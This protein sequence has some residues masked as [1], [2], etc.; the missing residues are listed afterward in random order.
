MLSTPKFVW[1]SENRLHDFPVCFSWYDL[2][3]DN[4]PNFSLP[5]LAWP[6]DSQLETIILLEPWEQG[7]E[8]L[9]TTLEHCSP[10]WDTFK[11]GLDSWS[12]R[13]RWASLEMA[14]S[15]FQRLMA[16]SSSLC[17]RNWLRE[18]IGIRKVFWINP[19]N[20]HLTSYCFLQAMDS[21][22]TMAHPSHC[23][24]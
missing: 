6:H 14:W 19:L 10:D 7:L 21:L 20:G 2:L 13:V 3:E 18:T 1:F 9:T 12:F 16:A 4:S 23:V 8:I 24:S 11:S 22:Q 15:L 5:C 17:F